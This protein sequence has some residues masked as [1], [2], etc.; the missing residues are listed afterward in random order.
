MIFWLNVFIGIISCHT[1]IDERRSEERIEP[2]QEYY[3]T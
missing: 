3:F 2:G 1:D